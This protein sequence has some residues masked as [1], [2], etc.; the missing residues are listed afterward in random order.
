[1]MILSFVSVFVSIPQIIRPADMRGS[2]RQ[3]VTRDDRISWYTLLI[4]QND[5]TWKVTISRACA[6]LLTVKSARLK[7]GRSRRD[8]SEV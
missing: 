8:G 4:A 6:F 7:E 3:L 2:I 5:M 1:M